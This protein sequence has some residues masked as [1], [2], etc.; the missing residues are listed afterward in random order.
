MKPCNRPKLGLPA[1]SIFELKSTKT[2]SFGRIGTVIFSSDAFFNAHYFD[3]SDYMYI[4]AGIPGVHFGM[5]E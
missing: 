1:D 5:I 3:Q 2:L 4:A